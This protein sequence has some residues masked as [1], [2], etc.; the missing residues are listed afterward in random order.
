MRILLSLLLF[1]FPA[2]LSAQGVIRTIPPQ[3]EDDVSHSY[4]TTLLTMAL[5][6]TEAEYGVS[7]VAYTTQMEQGRAVEELARGRTLDVYWAGTSISREKKLKPVRLPLLKGL[8]GFRVS[9]IRRDR[10]TEFDRVE[11]LQKLQTLVA[12]QGKHWPDSDVLEAA[13]IQVQRGL[14]M[15]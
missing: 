6:Q 3:S 2:M 8:L 7:R 12:C 15:S 13:G 1:I 14:S 5:R 9:L 11:T 4:F 10:Q